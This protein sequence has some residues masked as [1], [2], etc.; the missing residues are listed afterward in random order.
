MLM[1]GVALGGW[2]KMSLSA[3]YDL[4]GAEEV[5]EE[6]AE[7]GSQEARS[8]RWHVDPDDV[9]RLVLEAAGTEGYG[10]ATVAW[11]GDAFLIVRTEMDGVHRPLHGHRGVCRV[12]TMTSDG[13]RS[14]LIREDPDVDVEQDWIIGRWEAS[15]DEGR[16]WKE[17]FDLVFERS[18]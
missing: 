6:H 2:S 16:T 1:G 5:G 4:P 8:A 10:S 11:L 7:R 14:T 12:F 9:G 3:V 15:K 13:M 18:P 17:D